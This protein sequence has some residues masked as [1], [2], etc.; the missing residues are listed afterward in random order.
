MILVPQQT[1]LRPL[2]AGASVLLKEKLAALSPVVTTLLPVGV[3]RFY[4]GI[5][6]DSNPFLTMFRLEPIEKFTAEQRSSHL[7]FLF[8]AG[9]VAALILYNVLYYYSL[10][11]ILFLYYCLLICA[12]L[13]LEAVI[14]G[15]PLLM[16]P[17]Y[18][19]WLGN[20]WI[21][22]DAFCMIG[23]T[24]FTSEYFDTRSKYP[25][26]FKCCRAYIVFCLLMLPCFFLHQSLIGAIFI[27]I[28]CLMYL[29]FLYIAGKEYTRRTKGTVSYMLS[30]L[31]ALLMMLV[32]MGQLLNI[33]DTSLSFQKMRFV[34]V[35]SWGI[36]FSV[37]YS[38]VIDQM[39]VAHA[40]LR[41][42]LTGLI[43]QPQ[44]DRMIAEGRHFTGEPVTRHLTVMFIDIVGYS[45]TIRDLPLAT[46]FEHLKQVLNEI[47][48]II[49]QYNGM[50][51]RSLGDGMI[52]FFGYD[53][54]GTN[55]ADHAHQ[56]LSAA[57]EIQQKSVM[58]IVGLGI[59]S[60]EPIFPLRIGIDSGLICVGN[61]GDEN[62]FEVALAGEGVFLARRFE[63]AC[64]PHKVI[65]GPA[66]F[67]ALPSFWQESG[68]ILAR[69]IPLKPK[70]DF[71]EGYEYDPFRDNQPLLY[72]AGLIL[73]QKL[74]NFSRENRNQIEDYTIR[75]ASLHG[76]ME[77][78]NFS[79]GG[80][81]LRSSV[82]LGRGTVYE[83]TLTPFLHVKEATQLNPL[84]VEVVWGAPEK[85][86]A[87]LLGVRIIDRNESQKHLLVTILRRGGRLAGH[88]A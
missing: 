58:R 48:S 13:C 45:K 82:Y 14:T 85:N 60:A 31:P 18:S 70:S 43:P 20:S 6:V 52:S 1:P 84:T 63:S 67:T 77:V 74:G 51:D 8:L 62:R 66:T 7:L 49:H 40:A 44:I 73:W 65:M 37:G 28:E 9:G 25:A 42:S 34:A 12:Y 10:R 36:L 33:F 86:R 39:R 78:V 19:F 55:A 41:S 87:Y 76:Q 59:H 72:E 50:I 47:T 88:A 61:L 16:D 27:A 24:L 3:S 22:W 26:Y 17:P 80:L 35:A 32:F 11:K 46:G 57:R 53:I 38:T 81:C 56:A 30:F 15:F 83:L 2:L 75:F 64:E 21:V 79:L 29:G 5:D 54:A 4:L 69:S 68:A 71:I 23:L